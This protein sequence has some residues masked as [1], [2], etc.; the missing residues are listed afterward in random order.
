MVPTTI[1]ASKSSNIKRNISIEKIVN[2]LNSA[3]PEESGKQ[4]VSSSSAAAIQNHQQQ[5]QQETEEGYLEM[6]SHVTEETT[7]TISTD[8]SN[9]EWEDIQKMDWKHMPYELQSVDAVLQTVIAMLMD[10]ARKVHQRSS[11]AMSE[12]R[13]EHKKGTGLSGGEHAQERLRLYKDEV[14]LMEGRVQGFVRAMNDC[15]EVSA[16]ND[17]L[18]TLGITPGRPETGYGYIEIDASETDDYFKIKSFKEK[19]NKK[20]SQKY[21]DSGVPIVSLC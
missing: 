14:N 7:T 4:T 12:L 13:G 18:L 3:Q 9:D 16:N 2:K 17:V 8:H 1:T 5:Q 15:L 6:D 21:L 11:G 10:D 20:D 19:P